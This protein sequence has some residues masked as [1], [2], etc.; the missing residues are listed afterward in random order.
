MAGRMCNTVFLKTS[1]IAPKQFL[2][3]YLRRCQEHKS[4]TSVVIK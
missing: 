3:F 4:Y 2:V 1:L